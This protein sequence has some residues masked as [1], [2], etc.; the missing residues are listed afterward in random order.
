MEP[1]RI[2]TLASLRRY[3]VKSMAGEEV[4]AARV[5]FAGLIG[6]RVHAFVD[7]N[8]KSR[9]PWMTARQAHDWLLFQPRFLDPPPLEEEN[10]GVERYATEVT[11][12]DGAEIHGGRR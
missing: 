6:D 2:G 12:P 10:P 5:T 11:V 3:P 4:A 8:N 7:E 9:F 1:E